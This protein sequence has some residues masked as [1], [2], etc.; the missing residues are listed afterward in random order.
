M[1]NSII[2]N[3]EL[4]KK[5]VEELFFCTTKDEVENA[6]HEANINDPV[7]KKFFLQKCM[8]VEESYDFPSKEKL[9]DIDEYECELA[10][11]LEGSWRLL[12]I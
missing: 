5:V 2:T 1:N 4:G 7:E 8:Q 11:F 12:I 10:I 3:Y 6:F 9:S